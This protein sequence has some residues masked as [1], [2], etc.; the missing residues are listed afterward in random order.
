MEANAQTRVEFDDVME[1]D[2]KSASKKYFRFRKK[3]LSFHP[4][5]ETVDEVYT[6]HRVLKCLCMFTRPIHLS[7]VDLD[8]VPTGN[9]CVL[10]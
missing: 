10:I 3:Q 4:G 2:F 5:R 6:L 9:D 8:H 7:F 1:K